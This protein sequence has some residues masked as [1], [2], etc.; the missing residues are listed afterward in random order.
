[1]RYTFSRCVS[2]YAF[3]KWVLTNQLRSI[4]FRRQTAMPS[5][6]RCRG[7]TFWVISEVSSRFGALYWKKKLRKKSPKIR[8]MGFFGNYCGIGRLKRVRSWC[9][10]QSTFFRIKFPLFLK[11]YLLGAMLGY[12]CKC[13]RDSIEY[14]ECCRVPDENVRSKWKLKS[15]CSWTGKTSQFWKVVIWQNLNAIF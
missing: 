6:S 2:T 4:L 12:R 1:M 7:F 5:I 15:F 11:L 8:R 3:N 14:F 13:K 10:S 9:L